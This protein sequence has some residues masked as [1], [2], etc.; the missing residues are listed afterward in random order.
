MPPRRLTVSPLVLL[1]AHPHPTPHTCGSM[2]STGSPRYDSAGENTPLFQSD[3]RPTELITRT[4]VQAS[5]SQ[6]TLTFTAHAL[7]TVDWSQTYGSPPMPR[8]GSA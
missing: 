1:L 2:S 8:S 3:L 5:T 4:Y 7:L 6:F